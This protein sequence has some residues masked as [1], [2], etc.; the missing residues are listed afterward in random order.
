MTT[1]PEPAANPAPIDLTER[2]S[3]FTEQWAPK[4][5]ATVNDYDVRIAKVQ[6]EFVWHTHPDTDEFFFVVA[7]DLTIRLR[8]VEYGEQEVSL[9]PGQLYVVPRGVE[10]C[11]VAA[12][13]ASILMFE[14]SGEPNTGD[15]GGERTREPAELD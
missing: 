14:P 13:E 10:H 7:G 4:R 6:G 11:P 5:I 3:R 12:D 9:A 8:T 15:V 2:F 1:D